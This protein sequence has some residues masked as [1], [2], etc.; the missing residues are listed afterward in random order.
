MRWAQFNFQS[1]SRKT[2]SK[3]SARLSTMTIKSLSRSANRT[4]SR[5]TT[6]LVLET[7]RISG[8]WRK[9]IWEA[10]DRWSIGRVKASQRRRLETLTSLLSISFFLPSFSSVRSAPSLPTR[11]KTP[12]LPCLSRPP[13]KD[14]I[15]RYFN[16][17]ISLKSIILKL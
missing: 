3:I 14:L 5:K 15:E 6:Q 1:I 17:K 8:N 16:I 9:T 11:S 2:C 10:L 7:R 4:C 13:A 12:D